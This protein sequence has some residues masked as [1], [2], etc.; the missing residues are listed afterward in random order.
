MMLTDYDQVILANQYKNKLCS[1]INNNKQKQQIK[2][3]NIL[4]RL[5]CYS[6]LIQ[7]MDRVIWTDF[8]VNTCDNTCG[9]F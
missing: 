9:S 3:K 2:K 1:V 4:W 5:N 6:T 7:H 8:F